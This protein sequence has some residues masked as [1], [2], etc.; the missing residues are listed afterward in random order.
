MHAKLSSQQIIESGAVTGTSAHI[1]I[2]IVETVV[3][4]DSYEDVYRRGVMS[5]R[6]EGV[7]PQTDVGTIE[8]SNTG[9]DES[10][11]I[12]GVSVVGE[13]NNKEITQKGGKVSVMVRE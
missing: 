9:R 13:V 2:D 12:T 7:S 6:S 10:S 4:A 1:A 11:V 5:G 3:P 8:E